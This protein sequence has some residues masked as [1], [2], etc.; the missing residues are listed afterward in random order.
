MYVGFSGPVESCAC[1]GYPMMGEKEF[2][3]LA[4]MCVLPFCHGWKM[5]STS[6]VGLL[7]QLLKMLFCYEV[8]DRGVIYRLSYSLIDDT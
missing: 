5:F 2:L 8:V 4:P 7:Q 3:L 1:C 6:Y